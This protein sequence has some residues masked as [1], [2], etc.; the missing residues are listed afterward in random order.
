MLMQTAESNLIKNVIIILLS[1]LYSLV[2]CRGSPLVTERLVISLVLVIIIRICNHELE[3]CKWKIWPEG[4][5]HLPIIKL[6][7]SKFVYLLLGNI[8]SIMSILGDSPPFWNYS[9]QVSYVLNSGWSE[10]NDNHCGNWSSPRLIEK[11]IQ[12]LKGCSHSN[13]AHNIHLL[14][15]HRYS[16]KLHIFYLLFYKTANKTPKTC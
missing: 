13:A 9:L 15:L 2:C 3:T 7:V 14:Q 16:L 5:S 6:L 4:T 11:K 1:S 10:N 8:L 12:A